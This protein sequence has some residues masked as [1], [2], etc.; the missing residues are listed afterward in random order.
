MSDN[1]T[2]EAV[3]EQEDFQTLEKFAGENLEKDTNSDVIEAVPPL[4]MRATIYIFGAVVVA[5]LLLAYF[6]KIF[7]IVQS[8]GNIIP[9]GQNVVVEAGSTGVLTDLRVALGDKVTVGQ[10]IAELRQDAAGVSLT[11]FNDQLKIENDRLAKFQ[12]SISLV[13]QLLKD[14]SVVSIQPME[15]F[16]DA[17]SALVF[18]GNLRNVMQKLNQLR[19]KRDVDL[20]EQKQMMEQQIKLQNTTIQSLKNREVTNRQS[21]ETTLQTVNLKRDELD[22]TTELAKNR[23]LTDQE[24]NLARDA[25]LSAQNTLNQQRRSLSD[26]RLDINKASIEVANLKNNFQNSTRNL[27][28]QIEETELAFEKAVSDLVS[29]TSTLSK[30]IKDSEA[31]ITEIRGKLRLQENSIQK[32]VI[33]SP[34][35]GEITALNFNSRGQ[36]VGQGNRFAVIVPTDVRPII[37]VTVAN[38]D[39]AGVREGI[40]ARVKVAAYPFR[41]YG[42]VKAQVT[43]VFPQPDKPAFNVRLRLDENFINVNGK[44]APLEPGL[45]VQVDLLTERKRILELIFK[46]MS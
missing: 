33:K 46:K 37:M 29:S 34:V 10:T 2:D 45:E 7:V 38:K 21:I 13:K 14:P 1:D 42:T 35:N 18:I 11:T 5:S 17:G 44:P 26:T 3:P 12:K 6:S 36:L 22:R 20:V 31:K 27:D 9:E 41:Q 28:N 25:L 15:N 23:V 40:G 39:I 43:R 4:Y 16:Q 19:F 30:S 8:K 32:L 24:V